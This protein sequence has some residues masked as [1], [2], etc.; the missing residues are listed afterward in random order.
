LS[1]S[2]WALVVES[3]D[4]YVGDK[5]QLWAC[6]TQL[7]AATGADSFRAQASYEAQEFWYLYGDDAL[8]TG[9]AAMLSDFVA[10]DMVFIY[11]TVLGSSQ[12]AGGTTI[13]WFTAESLS[14]QGSCVA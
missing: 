11:V 12:A 4:N 14:R 5:Y 3:P 10:N 9:T 2:E 8:F 7:D 13:P 6:I 1:A